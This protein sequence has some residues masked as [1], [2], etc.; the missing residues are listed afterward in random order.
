MIN[1]LFDLVFVLIFNFLLD[2][3]RIR[4]VTFV[5]RRWYDVIYSSIVWI[6]VDFDF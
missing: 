3:E 6:K 1:I 5:C 2:I 4:I